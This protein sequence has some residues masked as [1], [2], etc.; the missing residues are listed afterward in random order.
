MTELVWVCWACFWFV[1][2]L[3]LFFELVSLFV[4]LLGV[5]A[6]LGV[7]LLHFLAMARV[8]DAT[9][10]LSLKRLGNYDLGSEAGC[11]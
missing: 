1:C 11:R 3:L 7:G 5:L 10:G 9:G 6:L 8:L 4:C 2:F